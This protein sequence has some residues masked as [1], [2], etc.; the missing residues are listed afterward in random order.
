MPTVHVCIMAFVP[1]TSQSHLSQYF[2]PKLLSYYTHQPNRSSLAPY[3]GG[4]IIVLRSGKVEQV[5]YTHFSHILTSHSVDPG[6]G[7]S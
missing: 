3:L 5:P 1:A 2:V 7:Q 4:T 6:N